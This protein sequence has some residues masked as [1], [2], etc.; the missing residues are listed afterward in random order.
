MA[1]PTELRIII[2]DDHPIFR[3]GLR[4][5]IESD[6]HLRVI[7]EADDGAAALTLIQTHQPQ[8]AVLD[9]DMPQLDGLSVA[10]ALREQ[11]SPTAVVFLTM[12]KD[13]ATFNAVL[14]A[15]VKGY[16]VKDGA[17]NEIVGAIKAVAAGQSYFS[18]VLSNHL[19]QHRKGAGEPGAPQS[20]LE[21]LSPTERRVLRLIAESKANKEIAE[22]LFISVRTVEH[23]RSNI[24]AKL[25][26]NGKHALLT[27]ALTHKSKL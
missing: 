9:M 21:T 10:R 20:G 1:V 12:H 14:N 8:I 3:R 5:V 23:H 17:A 4:L 24:C 11:Q 26:L 27:F 19:L 6:P 15:G 16:V 7:A 2:A 18:P 22:L 25:G 13:E